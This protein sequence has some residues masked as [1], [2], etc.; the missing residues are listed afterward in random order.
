M[1]VAPVTSL[2]GS[3]FP[4]PD[5]ERREGGLCFQTNEEQSESIVYP[6]NAKVGVFVDAVHLTR[7]GGYGMQY[8]VSRPPLK[9]RTIAMEKRGAK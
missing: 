1:A 9:A 8:D 4:C 3:L 7:N 5:Q 6:K 2:C